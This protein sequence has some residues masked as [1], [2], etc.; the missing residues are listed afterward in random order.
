VAHAA[1]GLLVLL[2]AAA[3]GMYKPRGLTR[4]GWR[5]KQ[6]MRQRSIASSG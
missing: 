5:Q 4:H 1:G 3:L 2:W 6:A